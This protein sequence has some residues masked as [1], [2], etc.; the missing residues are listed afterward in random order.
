MG[1]VDRRR[2]LSRASSRSF[3]AVSSLVM[4]AWVARS[5]ARRTPSAAATRISEI[6]RP[7]IAITTSSS[8]R[9]NPPRGDSLGFRMASA[10]SLRSRID[11]GP[12]RARPPRARLSPAAR[13]RSWSGCRTRDCGRPSCRRR[14]CCRRRTD[15]G[16]IG[17]SPVPHPPLARMSRPGPRPSC[18]AQMIWNE[19]GLI[20]ATVPVADRG[21]LRVRVRAGRDRVDGGPSRS[22]RREADREPT[23][24]VGRAV[25]LLL[26][27]R[28]GLLARVPLPLTSLGSYALVPYEAEVSVRPTIARGDVDR[29]DVG[30]DPSLSWSTSRPLLNS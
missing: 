10:V 24:D 25:V 2:V 16:R 26:V 1:L 22:C 7:M 9:V 4:S 8:T 18:P 27:D 20:Q 13:R 30:G 11:R 15:S 5:S 28:A 19:L 21:P 17:S 3:R 29:V 6:I 23:L 14:G 12:A